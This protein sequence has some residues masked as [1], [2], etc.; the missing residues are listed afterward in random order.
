[1]VKITP[2]KFFSCDDI[3]KMNDHVWV[4]G[5]MQG[6]K[7][8]FGDKAEPKPA[9]EMFAVLQFYGNATR[10]FYRGE[11]PKG[12]LFKEQAVSEYAKMLADCNRGEQPYTYGERLNAY[13]VGGGYLVDQLATSRDKL[14]EEIESDIQSNR[15][16]GMLWNPVDALLQSPPCFNWYQVRTLEPGST[17]V[18]LRLLFRSHDYGNG[19]AA[20]LCGITKVFTDKVIEPAGGKLEEIILVSTSGHIYD[21]D[22]DMVYSYMPGMEHF[23][24]GNG[25]TGDVDEL[26]R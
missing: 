11:V 3:T 8:L 19:Y 18:S 9:T 12:W 7:I 26:D 25:Y 17:D 23:I 16:V 24:L 13:D 20:N 4:T 6:K 14:E 5:L 22:L 10:Q 2:I 1:M 21:N 15:N